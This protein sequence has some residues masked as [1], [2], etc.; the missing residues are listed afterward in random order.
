MAAPVI[1]AGGSAAASATGSGTA[2]AGGGLSAGTI[3]RTGAGAVVP[4]NNDDNNI[5]PWLAGAVVTGFLLIVMLPVLIVTAILPGSGG[6]EQIGSGSPIPA[7]LVPVFNS[8][9]QTFD[10]NPYLLASVAQQESGMGGGTDWMSPN[11]ADCV[12]FMQICIGGQGGDTWDESETLT[13]HPRATIV[14]KNAYRYG[15]RPSGYPD[16]TSHHPSYN[17]PF[18]AVMAAA[19]VLR[20]KVGGRPI[21]NLDATAHAAACGYYGACADSVANYATEV[22][23]RAIEWQNESALTTGSSGSL[24]VPAGTRL[25]QLIS[26]A[27]QIGAMHIPYC[28]G[29]GHG[30]TP[31]PS[32]GQWCQSLSG[33]QIEGDTEPGLDCSGSVRWALT[34]IG[35]KDPGGIAAG[36]FGSWLLP[37]RG[38]H[39]DVYW[40]SVHTFMVVD[41]RQWGTGGAASNYRGGPNWTTG[42]VTQGF[43][44]SHPPGL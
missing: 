9:A 16:A 3:A 36:D 37:G 13:G 14:V 10:V 23:A 28:W 2:A 5:L 32:V 17:D 26:V 12:G 18:D 6:P 38:E 27:T 43:N 41:G 8:A 25:Q 19:V 30:A 22:M 40:N 24:V 31:G 35:I 34:A 4:R 29:G 1:A 42:E 33:A 20:G 15:T 11:S 39:V 21:P 44:V 7:A